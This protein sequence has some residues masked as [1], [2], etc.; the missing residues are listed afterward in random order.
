MTTPL[1]DDIDTN[2]ELQEFI[3]EP[4]YETTIPCHDSITS[5]LDSLEKKCLSTELPNEDRFRAF[6]DM[7]SSPYINRS[8]RCTRVL[9]IVLA[10][11]S[12]P[13][14]ARFSWL[15]RL[16]VSS[17]ALDV[18]LYGYVY[19]FYTYDTPIL[20]KLLC[21]QFMLSHPLDEYP[22]MKTHMKFSQQWLYNVSK[23][24]SQT[25]Q[26]RSEASD[27]LIRLGTP[28]FRKVATDIIQSMGTKYVN[29]RNRTIY[30]HSQ[31][32]HEM[33]HVKEM[34]D[35]LIECTT[36]LTV[37]MDTILQWVSTLPDPKSLESFQRIVMDTAVYNNYRLT[38]IL[39]HVVQRIQSSEHRTELE[40]RLM[41]ELV[42]MN[43]WCS[44]GHLIRLLNTLHGFDPLVRVSL[45]VKEE[46]RASVMARLSTHMRMCSSELKEEL[47]MAFTSEDKDLLNEFVDTYSPYDELKSEYKDLDPVLF[48]EYYQNAIRIFMG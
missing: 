29:S 14:E 1:F 17:D 31:N 30:N 41:E 27:M 20:Y 2:V 46:I 23:N 9:L 45:P 12:L 28:N 16:K 44:T 24:E 18:C 11:E 25:E 36:P 40:Q 19:W 48:E 21:A 15:T 43:G 39:C 34:M 5:P 33:V 38:E 32:I 47:A 35:A 7:Y 13:K 3:D 4:M 10:D 42:E 8:E 26:I 37:Q 6:Q 22:F